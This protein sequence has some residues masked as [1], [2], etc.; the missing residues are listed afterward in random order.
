MLLIVNVLANKYCFARLNIKENY[1]NS[2][3]FFNICLPISCVS[4]IKNHSK[5][6]NAD[7][8]VTLHFVNQF[9]FENK[10]VKKLCRNAV[11]ILKY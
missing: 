5:M 4:S 2:S 11:Q 6:N 3:S 10:A 7:Y 9:A 1:N 8:F